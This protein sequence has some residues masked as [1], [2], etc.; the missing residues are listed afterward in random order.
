MKS[1]IFQDTKWSHSLIQL[2]CEAT[3]HRREA[4]ETVSLVEDEVFDAVREEE[5]GGSVQTT[6]SQTPPNAEPTELSQGA[7]A[8]P[9]RG[10]RGE[11][12]V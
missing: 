9:C 12:T 8:W 1:S 2:P 5:A 7:G 6:P 11:E 3:R 10:G 4:A